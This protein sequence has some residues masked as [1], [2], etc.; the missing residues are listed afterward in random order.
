MHFPIFSLQ[1]KCTYIAQ[2]ISIISIF[3]Y[4]IDAITILS[5]YTYLLYWI[6]TTQ[7]NRFQ[8]ANQ[9]KKRW[10]RNVLFSNQKIEKQWFFNVW[11]K[12]MIDISHNQL[13]NHYNEFSMYFQENLAFV[14]YSCVLCHFLGV[15]TRFFKN[16]V[17]FL[18]NIRN[19]H[20]LSIYVAYVVSW[21]SDLFPLGPL[22]PA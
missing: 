2:V 22:L 9:V 21:N 8:I 18:P 7:I 4:V 16:A 6:V 10:N 13:L 5:I 15:A 14:P 12:I 19:K 3:V 11:K 17:I 20:P 1:A